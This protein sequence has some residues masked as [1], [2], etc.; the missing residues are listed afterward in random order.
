MDISEEV[1]DTGQDY[2]K[3]KRTA[4][5]ASILAILICLAS[6]DQNGR[7][8]IK[9]LD[10]DV[11]V[12]MFSLFTIMF[13]II[14]YCGYGYYIHSSREFI[15][16][17]E[18]VSKYGDLTLA[19]A[20]GRLKDDIEKI[21]KSAE[22]IA[23]LVDDIETAATITG[24]PPLEIDP[25]LDFISEIIFRTKDFDLVGSVMTPLNFD[26]AAVEDFRRDLLAANQRYLGEINRDISSDLQSHVRN[27]LMENHRNVLGFYNN[28]AISMRDAAKDQIP[29]MKSQIESVASSINSLNGK[30][31]PTE[32]RFF[33]VETG[34]IIIALYTSGIWCFFKIIWSMPFALFRDVWL[35]LSA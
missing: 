22:N 33:Y 3:S 6:P 24:P 19:A 7:F 13:F 10:V 17:S 28:S 14:L 8:N 25:N 5:L 21:E 11:S 27:Y 20:L 18:M 2:E 32:K 9:V 23:S 1:F 16:H 15:K 30:I 26:S 31:A 34:V 12:P 4:L 35:H 29:I